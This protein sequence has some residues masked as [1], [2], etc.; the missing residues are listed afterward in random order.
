[1]L[2]TP[3]FAYLGPETFVPLATFVAAG[4]GILVAFGKTILYHVG[5]LGGYVVRV[6]RRR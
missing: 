1:M 4:L 3:L 5:R 2:T 6:F